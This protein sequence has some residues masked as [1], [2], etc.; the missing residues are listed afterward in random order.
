M[1]LRIFKCYIIIFK[2]DQMKKIM[3]PI[4]EGIAENEW[5]FIL[6]GKRLLDPHWVGARVVEIFRTIAFL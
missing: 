3:T 5:S 4:S 6:F 1:L 2:F